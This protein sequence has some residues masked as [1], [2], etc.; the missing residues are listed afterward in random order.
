MTDWSS[1]LDSG[2]NSAV[3]DYKWNV[4]EVRVKVEVRVRVRVKV[5]FR[6]YVN[7]DYWGLDY[8]WNLGE[9]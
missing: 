2:V 9:G 1:S 8:G 5:G 3:A 4:V 7:I 6:G